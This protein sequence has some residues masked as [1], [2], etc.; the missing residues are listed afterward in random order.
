MDEKVDDAA[1]SSEIGA[2]E[3]HDMGAARRIVP[4]VIGE[5]ERERGKRRC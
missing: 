5:R 2:R 3:A 1:L 4:A